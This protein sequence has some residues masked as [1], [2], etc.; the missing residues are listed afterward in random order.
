[1]SKRKFREPETAYSWADQTG[2]GGDPSGS[3]GGSVGSGP[4]WAEQSAEK[5][6]YGG[7]LWQHLVFL[8]ACQCRFILFLVELLTT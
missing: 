6:K 7:L 2:V 5:L 1:M 8:F 3:Q 4:S